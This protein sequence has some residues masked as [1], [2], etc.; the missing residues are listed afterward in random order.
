M[1]DEL[2]LHTLL[3]RAA[4]LD[5]LALAPVDELIARARRRR[6]VNRAIVSATTAVI[7]TGATVGLPALIRA[8]DRPT[9]NAASAR[10]GPSGGTANTALALRRDHWSILP[11]A[12]LSRRQQPT[13]AWTGSELIEI[14]GQQQT[15]A[16]TFSHSDGAAYVPGHG[17]KLIA[18]APAGVR[19]YDA[20]SVW[21]GTRLFLFG[22]PVPAVGRQRYGVPAGLYDPAANS[23][24]VTAPSPLRTALGTMTAVWTGRTVVVA[25]ISD[26]TVQVASYDPVTGGWQSI[27]PVLPAKQ[28]AFQVGMTVTQGRVLLWTLSAHVEAFG[29]PNPYEIHVW[30]LL[31]HGHWQILA[32]WPQ[33]SAVGQPLPTEPQLLAASGLWCLRCSLPA[34]VPQSAATADRATILGSTASAGPLDTEQPTLAWTGT[35]IIAVAAFGINEAGVHYKTGAMADWDPATARWHRLPSAP[36]LLPADAALTWTG[37]QLLVLANDGSLLT[38]GR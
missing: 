25:G 12:P 9:H 27:S 10:P 29:P 8:G 17:W 38:F 35:V 18:A 37:K 36:R 34:G 11:A 20:V 33:L 5:D 28:F 30:D 7:V 26:G 21:T 22:D 6:L 14:G 4:E 2:R 3:N 16:G 24:T 23:W 31:S 1:V 13:V 19:T 15:P 32:G